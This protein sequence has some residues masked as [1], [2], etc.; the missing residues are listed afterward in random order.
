MLICADVGRA[1]LP[2]SWLLA[3]W[4]RWKAGPRPGKAAPHNG[5]QKFLILVTG[6]GPF[7]LKPSLLLI[8][9]TL[10]CRD[11]AVSAVFN[12]R[13]RSLIH[14]RL[15]ILSL[16]F[17]FAAVVLPAAQH[18]GTVRTADQPVPGATVTATIGDKKLTTSTGEDGSYV[19][20]DLPAGVWLI[21]VEM[22]GFTRQGQ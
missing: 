4:T 3:G 13:E 21:E 18:S 7:I 20:R 2:A 14:V 10:F 19:F 5:S 8:P 12:R 15:I 16:G 11:I 22:F 17:F 1:I 6:R 9:I